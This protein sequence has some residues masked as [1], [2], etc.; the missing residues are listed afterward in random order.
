MPAVDQTLSHLMLTVALWWS[1]LPSCPFCRGGCLEKLRMELNNNN[2]S[3]TPEWGLHFR[4]LEPRT[5]AFCLDFCSK[6]HWSSLEGWNME[7][8]EPS[9]QAPCTDERNFWPILSVSWAQWPILSPLPVC[10]CGHHPSLVWSFLL[11]FT[12]TIDMY[13]RLVS[14]SWSVWFL[15]L[16]CFHSLSTLLLLGQLWPS[17]DDRGHTF[18][19]Q[20]V[21]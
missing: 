9:V 14:P 3:H 18:Y 17:E 12:L 8:I 19:H 15:S 11:P 2:N 16:P 7:L 5:H 21:V 6:F 10:F 13:P 20:V 1:I 4:P